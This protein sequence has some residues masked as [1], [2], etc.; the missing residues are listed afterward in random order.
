MQENSSLF[1]ELEEFRSFFF[2]E[3]PIICVHERFRSV[4]EFV[5]T[6]LLFF[7]FLSSVWLFK[8]NKKS[9]AF[10]CFHSYFRATSAGNIVRLSI[11]SKG[12]FVNKLLQQTIKMSMPRA[13]II[14]NG[15]SYYLPCLFENGED[16]CRCENQT[17]IVRGI[18]G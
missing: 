16:L 14:Q 11:S 1:S 4:F 10:K 15:N 2:H 7:I 18:R 12:I 9:F 3:L 17:S 8:K 5:N 6:K 13:G